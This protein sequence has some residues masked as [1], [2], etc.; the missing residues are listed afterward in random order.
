MIVS[1]ASFFLYLQT[2][3]VILLVCDGNDLALTLVAST[4]SSASLGDTPDYFTVPDETLIDLTHWFS[5]RVR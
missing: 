2:F 5:A 4:V 3:P 1:V